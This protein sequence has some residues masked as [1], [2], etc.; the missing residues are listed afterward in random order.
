MPLLGLPN[1]EQIIQPIADALDQMWA[2]LVGY[3]YTEHKD[4]G[5]HEAVTADSVTLNE[6][7]SVTFADGSTLTEV[8]GVLTLT[9]AG[10]TLVLKSTHNGVVSTRAVLGETPTAE[11]GDIENQI[12]DATSVQRLRLNPQSSYDPSANDTSALF[13]SAINS[14]QYSVYRITDAQNIEGLYTTL[15]ARGQVLILI[16]DSG[17]NI[18]LANLNA[19]SDEKKILGRPVTIGDNGAVL[20]VYD[21]TNQGWQIVGT[22]RATT[23]PLGMTFAGGV[24]AASLSSSA[25]VVA[26]TSV[27]ATTDYYEQGRATPVGHWQS[28]TPSWAA[29]G[30]TQ[31]AIGDGTL[32]GEYARI[33]DTIHY[34]ITLVAGGTT[35]FGSG[36]AWTFSLPVTAVSYDGETP[37]ATVGTLDTST[38]TRAPGVA[39]SQST[40]TIL[41]RLGAAGTVITNALPWTWANGDK[42]SLMG[43]YQAA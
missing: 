13:E 28:Y 26:G 10:E 37:L 33:G 43:T 31:P 8:D 39:M 9:S 40:T 36:G 25:E 7:G 24:S 27:T 3:L 42:V 35:T 11:P 17:G 32:T 6:D 2:S 22:W 21:N 16:N 1:R 29:I 18:S 15:G 30:G 4:D 19:V 23:H 12:N 20:L 41:P 38:S 34:R 14:P 5:T